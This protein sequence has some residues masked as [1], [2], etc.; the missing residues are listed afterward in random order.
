M[1]RR[2]V[3]MD[4]RPQ[5]ISPEGSTQTSPSQT[6][7]RLVHQTEVDLERLH[8]GTHIPARRHAKVLGV[9]RESQDQEVEGN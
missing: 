4:L 6:P 5:E 7:I 3:P 9:T 2:Y 8:V 1:R